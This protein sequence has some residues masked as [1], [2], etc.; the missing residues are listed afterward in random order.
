M[1]SPEW[2][3]KASNTARYMSGFSRFFDVAVIG[4]WDLARMER[5]NPLISQTSNLVP[6]PK[7]FY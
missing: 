7:P 6:Q 3:N 5:A 2:K 1:P 4:C